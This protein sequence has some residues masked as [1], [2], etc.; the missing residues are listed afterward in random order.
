MPIC[1][2][3]DAIRAKN[4]KHVPQW[5]HHGE[6]DDIIPISSSRKMVDALN[7]AQADEVKFSRYPDTGHDSWTKAYNDIE[8]WRWM[9]KHRREGGRK[10]IG[11]ENGVI[12]PEGN[13]V[14]VS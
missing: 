13:K 9:L 1:G 7:K 10:E 11:E 5:V 2:G 3:G 8:V 14:Q 4:I 12:V 6:R